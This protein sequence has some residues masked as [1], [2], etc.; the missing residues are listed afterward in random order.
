M[1]ALEKLLK[2]ILIFLLFSETLLAQGWVTSIDRI[3]QNEYILSLFSIEE[4]GYIVVSHSYSTNT[5]RLHKLNTSGQLLWTKQHEQIG[6]ETFKSQQGGYWVFNSVFA[7]DSFNLAPNLL[8]RL[9]GNGDILWSTEINFVDPIP[10]P[11]PTIRINTLTEKPNGDLLLLA[12]TP[13]EINYI[14]S[15]NQEGEVLS[16]Q[17][18]A[19]PTPDSTPERITKVKL[20]SDG[21]YLLLGNHNSSTLNPPYNEGLFFM[22]MDEN[23]S[24][25]WYNEFAAFQNDPDLTIPLGFFETADQGLI[26]GTYEELEGGEVI[27][28]GLDKTDSLGN[29]QWN[30]LYNEQFPNFYPID[31]LQTSNG[32]LVF[33]TFQTNDNTTE[34]IVLCRFNS[35]GQIKW[36]KNI[37][38]DIQG[39]GKII[40][41]NDNGFLLAGLTPANSV[42]FG[43][44]VVAKTDAFGNIFSNVITGSVGLDE[45]QNC[46][47]DS[48]EQKYKQWIVRAEGELN[49]TTLTD[50]LG[51]YSISVDTGAYTLNA[52]PPADLWESCPLPIVELS[53]FE[54]TVGVNL[55]QQSL[56]DCPLLHVDISTPFLRRCFDNDYTVTYCNQGTI[57]AEDAY[58]EVSFDSALLVNSSTIPWSTID[59]NT[60]TFLLGDLPQQDCG[61]FKI[62]VTVDCENTVL[63]QSHCTTAHIYPDSLCLPADENWDG[64][65]LIVT[66]ACEP[67]SVRFTVRNKGAGNM[68]APTSYLVVEDN[69]ML[70]Q[71][72]LQLNSQ[73]EIDFAYVANGSTYYFEVA[74]TPGHPRTNFANAFVEG[75]VADGGDFSIG[76]ANQFPENDTAPFVSIDCQ[77]NIGA[78]DP[79]DKIGYPIGWSADHI[80]EINQNIEY[81]IRFQ[82][83]GTDTAFNVV[84]LDTLSEHLDISTFRP[85]V[86]SHPYKIDFLDGHILQYTFEN[87]MLPDSNINEAASH[88]FFKFKIDQKRDNPLGTTILNSAAIYFDFNEP[89]ITNETYHIIGER[90]V[91]SVKPD[92]STTTKM[93]IKIYP[94]P[95]EESAQIV[96]DQ[97]IKLPI[98]FKVYNALGKKLRHETY[99]SNSFTFNRNDL[100]AGIYFYQLLAQG[101]MISNGKVIV[102]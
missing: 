54:D 87:I 13:E 53:G 24:L 102:Q 19:N 92:P 89:V 78:Y 44:L 47:L 33:Y 15:I 50:S 21:N 100:P 88:G 23:G 74:Q 31:F 4:E 86:A 40:N 82:N 48:T 52:I 68:A 75:C 80:I 49:Y 93:P 91:V 30:I 72:E 46:L 94:N 58:I 95:F 99:Q 41:T 84:V 70:Y 39:I 12:D 51:N 28:F 32:D 37:E 57:L 61:S 77:D 101:K 45:N 1:A 6:S 25:I 42:D 5:T 7:I 16:N 14:F 3:S 67:D 34:Q 85:G 35:N 69:V 60:Y 43:K 73:E 90:L 81:R 22:K 76:F 10:S 55:P 2:L 64:A 59:E 83:T 38:L 36:L 63:G 9:D 71:E 96:L 97:N 62:N 17:E 26:V 18:L 27:S 98:E 11:T 20:I 8:T 79:N 65:S 56:Y 66:E 29:E